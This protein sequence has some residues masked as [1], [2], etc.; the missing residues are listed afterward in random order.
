[1]SASTSPLRI[2]RAVATRSAADEVTAQFI[3]LLRSGA[4]KP[5]D[6]LPS[7][8]KLAQAFGVGRST[9]REAKRVLMAK[10]MLEARGKAGTYVVSGESP[11]PDPDLLALFL[12]GKALDD[13]YEAREVV[14]VA[15]I[16]LAAQRVENED[17][18]QIQSALDSLRTAIRTGDDDQ[19][20]PTGILF[21]ASLVKASHN[22]ALVSIYHV[23]SNLI[24]HDQLPEYRKVAPTKHEWNSHKRLFDAV[25]SRDPGAA[26]AAM[27]HHLRESHDRLP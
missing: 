20:W 6:R 17:L 2:F 7:E 27:H 11:F 4:M 3:A 19:V 5:G 25:V 16:R 15:A 24:R 8:P 1:M 13:L 14:E 10:A 18:T 9:V 22:D 26:E 23:L 21:H 12:T